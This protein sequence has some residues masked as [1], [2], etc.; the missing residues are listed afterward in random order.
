MK[1]RLTYL[2]CFFA[3]IL[4]YFLLQ[5][6]VFMLYNGACEKGTAF[7]DYLRVL[8]H[9]FTLDAATTGYL[10]AIP[11]L[12]ILCSIWFRRF[13][14]KK[15]LIGYYVLISLATTLIF[16]GDMAYIR[17]GDL[18]WTLPSSSIWTHRRM[19]WPAY[20]WDLF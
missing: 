10:T 9:G 13:P 19:P 11:W 6:P 16:I 8:F 4:G 17:S 1:K 12:T 20:P 5:K 14:L 7:T 3:S 2:G 15:I 18:N